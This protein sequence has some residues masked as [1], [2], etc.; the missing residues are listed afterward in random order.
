MGKSNKRYK[1]GMYGG[2]FFPFHTGHL[3]EAKEW[4]LHE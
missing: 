4:M 2:K 1:S 3:N